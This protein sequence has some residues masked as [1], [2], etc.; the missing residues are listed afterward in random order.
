MTGAQ[1]LSALIALPALVVGIGGY[2]RGPA[3]VLVHY[4]TGGAAG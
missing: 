2:K 4:Q 3:C 1:Q